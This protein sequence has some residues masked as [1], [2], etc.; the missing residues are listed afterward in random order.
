MACSARGPLLSRHT[1]RTSVLSFIETA[2]IFSLPC[3]SLPAPA[4]ADRGAEFDRT[5]EDTL[6]SREWLLP[7]TPPC[8]GVAR[9]GRRVLFALGAR[10]GAGELAHTA[11]GTQWLA[12]EYARRGMPLDAVY[13]WEGGGM[14]AADFWA[15]LSP[16][17]RRAG[18]D[19]GGALMGVPA[20]RRQPG[21]PARM[22]AAP[23]GLGGDETARRPAIAAAHR[24]LPAGP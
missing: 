1:L 10:P 15:T 21:K 5:A 14:S 20:L 12:D 3:H 19:T 8:E 2:L 6:F 13:A 23:R 24:P 18:A 9:L 17:M 16:D 22:P 7:T 11:G 4:Q